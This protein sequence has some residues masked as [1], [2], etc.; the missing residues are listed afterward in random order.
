LG[1][2]ELAAQYQKLSDEVKA[3][4]QDEFFSKNG[5]L[6]INTQTAY[7]LAFVPEA[8]KDRVVKDLR[9][10]LISDSQFLST[11][12]LPSVCLMPT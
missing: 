1:K 4:I 11:P 6:D 7:V 9:K 3:A 8:F 2:E 12:L 10:R 5:R